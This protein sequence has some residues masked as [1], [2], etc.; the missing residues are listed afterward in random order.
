MENLTGWMCSMRMAPSW[1]VL[2]TKRKAWR[3]SKSTDRRIF[4]EKWLGYCKE[5]AIRFLFDDAKWMNQ[6]RLTCPLRRFRPEV[7][8]T[9]T[10]C[11]AMLAT[12]YTV[13]SGG[14]FDL[15]S[16]PN[17]LRAPVPGCTDSRWAVQ[18]AR[19]ESI[20]TKVLEKKLNRAIST[21]WE[22]SHERMFE[23]WRRA[24]EIDPSDICVIISLSQI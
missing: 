13:R 1:A 21:K 3:Y 15:W 11:K 19:M 8:E 9:A 6:K 16:R 7:G 4:T 24:R 14:S 22:L 2:S 5:M 23:C 20:K 18:I 10:G 12:A 17:T